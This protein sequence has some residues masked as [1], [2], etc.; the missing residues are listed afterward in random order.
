MSK[1]VSYG[2]DTEDVYSVTIMVGS[3]SVN[4]TDIRQPSVLP[5]TQYYLQHHPLPSYIA[6]TRVYKQLA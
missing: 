3:E 2:T 5:L 6:P 4:G 1:V